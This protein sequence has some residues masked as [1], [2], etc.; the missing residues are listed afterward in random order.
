MKLKRLT[1]NQPYRSLEQ[2]FEIVFEP[3]LLSDKLD[4]ICLVGPNGSGK[5][6]ILEALADIFYYLDCEIL[7]Y[8]HQS[9]FQVPIEA[10]EIEYFLPL[11]W[12]NRFLTWND[13]WKF[14]EKYFKVKI[15][16]TTFAPPSFFIVLPDRDKLIQPGERTH[17]LPTK[18]WGYSSGANEI[19][20][21]PF[22]KMDLF[23]FKQVE[24]SLKKGMTEIIEDNR[25]HFVDYQT[26]ASILLANFIMYSPTSGNSSDA[27]KLLLF[28]EKFGIEK[29]TSFKFTI[30][31]QFWMKKNLKLLPEI[32][33]FISFLTENLPSESVIQR[34][35]FMSFSIDLNSDDTVGVFKRIASGASGLYKYFEKLNLLN[36]HTIPKE[37][38]ENVLFGEDEF[39]AQTNVSEVTDDRKPFIIDEVKLKMDHIDEP[40]LY[41]TIS[42]GEHQ[43]L[44]I[45]GLF[46]MIDE[47]GALCLLDE[48]ETHLNPK[49]K[50][51]FVET[52]NTISGSKRNQV[53]ITTHDPIFI[54]GLRKEDVILFNNRKNIA[55]GNLRWTQPDEDLKGLGVDN[56]LTSTLFGL[57]SAIDHPTYVKMLDRRVLLSKQILGETLTH[58]EQKKLHSLTEELSDIEGI[59]PVSDPLY[60]EF[61]NEMVKENAISNY[62]QKFS[63]EETN[64]NRER[65][66]TRIVEKLRSEGKL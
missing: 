24:G 32:E 56:I 58:E 3:D 15:T 4:P 2:G 52:L 10:F 19:L 62:Y 60:A 63:S 18:I 42:D 50:Y 48:P 14:D 40:I 64:H 25:L 61:I 39:Y 20:S 55:E 21:V 26:C 12:G 6:N 47:E 44:N 51:D 37:R 16:K 46:N 34:E 28:R 29:I 13:D 22:F 33:R 57:E 35:E 38:R 54:S 11:N 30:R 23:Y 53:L 5:S 36:V 43:A 7:G 66:T 65:I 59:K 31:N 17:V 1:L 49:W 8:T 41:K 45:L 9:K 27:H